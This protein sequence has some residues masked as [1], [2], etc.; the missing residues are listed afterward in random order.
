MVLGT[1]CECFISKMGS[2]SCDGLFGTL[3]TS[4]NKGYPSSFVPSAN[5]RSFFRC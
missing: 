4:Y 1:C 3:L 5:G 2:Q